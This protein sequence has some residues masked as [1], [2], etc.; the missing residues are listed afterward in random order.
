MNNNDIITKAKK[1]LCDQRR[2]FCAKTSQLYAQKGQELCRTP[3]GSQIINLSHMMDKYDNPDWQSQALDVITSSPVYSRMDEREN[4][5][6]EFDYTDE[7]VRQLLKWFKDDFFKW[8]NKL[9]CPQCD[10]E[11]QDKIRGL[12]ATRPAL[13]EHF[14]GQANVIEKYQCLKCNLQYHFPRYNNPAT[15]LTTRKGRCG[16]WNNCFILLL[17]SL[18]L[19][20][21]YVWNAEDHVWCEYFSSHLKRWIHLDACENSFDNP[22]LY[23]NGWGKKMS[24]SFAIHKYYILD[25]SEKY[26]DPQ[27]LD[28]HIKRNK[29]SS[30]DLKT[31]L[32]YLNCSKLGSI[33][34]DF[35][36]LSS[37]SRL[38]C[39]HKN[40]TQNAASQTYIPRTSGSPTWTKIRGESG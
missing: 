28:C 26:L 11:D 37:T 6:L 30:I 36:F 25:V 31:L 18:G 23:N 8:V 39:D 29:M 12:G 4:A 7:L 27:K 32:A 38:L 24:Y 22:F 15:L 13:K 10:N 34:D 20:V 17:V 9:P 16:E 21:R 40:D 35:L 14:D 19:D 1:A 33:K 2:D 5:G 3:F